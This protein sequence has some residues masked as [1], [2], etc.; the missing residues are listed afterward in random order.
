MAER[1]RKLGDFKRV[2]HF[3]AKFYVEGLRFAPLS[4]D[5]RYENGHVKQQR[6]AIVSITLGYRYILTGRVH[7]SRKHGARRT[8]KSRECKH[9]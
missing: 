7:A 2:G 1:P 3:E 8:I 6:V 5:I 9:S 4:M